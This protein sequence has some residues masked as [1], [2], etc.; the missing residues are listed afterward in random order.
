[1]IA[2]IKTLICPDREPT[3]RKGYSVL[4]DGYDFHRFGHKPSN[5]SLKQFDVGGFLRKPIECQN[6]GS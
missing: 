6:S 2:E 5:T 1:M 4:Q 3:H